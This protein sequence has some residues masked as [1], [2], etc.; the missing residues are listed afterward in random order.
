MLSWPLF[1]IGDTQTTLGSLLAVIAVVIAT[2]Y[3]G[4]LARKIM[5]R[6]VEK[7]HVQDGEVS[8]AYG[9]V[10]QLIVWIIGFEI[11]LHL[12]GIQLT[13]LFAAG[14]FFAI[15][16]GFAAKS[17]FE[18]FLSGEI[19]RLE[20]TI[21]P[22]DVVIEHQNNKWLVIESIGLRATKAKT[23]DGE[24]V[25]VPNS[26]VAQSMVENLTRSDRLYRLEI[27]VG[28]GRELD[29]ETIREAL[30]K[31]VDGLEW[32]ST[33][34]APSIYMDEIG[35]S[36]VQYGIVVWIDD[37]ADARKRRSDLHRAI[38]RIL[39]DNSINIADA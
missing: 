35:D 24:E 16:I 39:Q 19:L 29:Q 18:N 25:L 38:W 9:I 26:T 2:V 10:P 8:S 36:S 5:Q 7:L 22:G 17:I 27:R 6:H 11:A 12:L 15:G 37:I 3:L 1:S 21:K 28:V 31:T 34:E 13:T 14:G 33:A 32:R 23:Y 4:R 30:E 20:R